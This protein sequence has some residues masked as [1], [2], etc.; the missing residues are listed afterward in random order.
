MKIECYTDT[1][2]KNNEDIYGITKSGAFVLDGA[3]ALTNKNYTSSGNDVCWMVQWW[4][5]YL[6]ENLDK[7]IY[8]IQEILQEGIDRFNKDYGKFV[9][10]ST[11]KPHEQLSAGIAIVRKNGELLEAYVL[12]DVEITIEDKGQEIVEITDHS[13]N[14]LDGEV[15]Q[16]MG[17]NKKREDQLVFKGFTQAELDILI[18][19]RSKM[20]KPGGYYILS[21]SKEAI[22]M[23]IYKTFPLES[24]EE[25]LLATDG[26]VPLRYKY[27]KKDLFDRI[28]GIGVKELIKELRNLEETDRDKRNIGR[29]KTHDDA[30]LV[31]LNFRLS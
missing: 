10:L 28:R 23:G 19:N 8:T 18:L 6:E 3:S 31:Y 22:D 14:N 29:L 25:C 7:T 9:D 11:L 30:T 21:H 1:I 16:M 13:L 24:I 27:S 4:K 5:E 26:L 2:K 20:N 15:I 12:G 17:R